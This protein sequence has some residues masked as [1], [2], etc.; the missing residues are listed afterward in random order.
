MR[1]LEYLHEEQALG[2]VYDAPDEAPSALC[3]SLQALDCAVVIL[4]LVISVIDL[5][6]PYLI[7]RAIDDHILGLSQPYLEAPADLVHRA[8]GD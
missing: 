2:K 7:K 4:L 1:A 8:G 6:R 5:A 3:S